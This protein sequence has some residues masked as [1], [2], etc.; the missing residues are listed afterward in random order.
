MEYKDADVLV[1]GALYIRS[2]HVGLVDQCKYS[3]GDVQATLIINLY[4]SVPL[5]TGG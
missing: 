2:E 4:L 5:P 3:T 1:R